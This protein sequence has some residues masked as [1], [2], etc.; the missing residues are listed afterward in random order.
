MAKA[1]ILNMPKKVEELIR[2]TR[3]E[4]LLED[5]SEEEISEE[6]LKVLEDLYIRMRTTN[7]Y[8]FER[9]GGRVVD[10]NQLKEFAE[11]F[12]VDKLDSWINYLI[13][14]EYIVRIFRGGSPHALHKF[15]S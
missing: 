14:R 11:I 3:E 15:H 5:L 8:L 2:R 12:N 6:G 10:K 1:K 4:L 9:F 7:R 13:N